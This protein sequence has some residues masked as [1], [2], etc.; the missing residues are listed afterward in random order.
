MTGDPGGLQRPETVPP[1]EGDDEELVVDAA[2]DEE[3]YHE[4][5]ERL[6]DELAEWAKPTCQPDGPVW[7]S[8]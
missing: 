3:G 8:G 1:W 2:E 7:R 4:V 5:T 6:L